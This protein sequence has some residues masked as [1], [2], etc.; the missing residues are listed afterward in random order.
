MKP[1]TQDDLLPYAEYDRQRDRIRQRIIDLKRHR[2]ISVGE[3]VTLVFENRETLQFQVQE[4]IRVERIVDPV[5]VP[6]ELDM[7]ND[8]LPGEGELSATLL[9][10]ITD[11]D[12]RKEQLDAFRG[13]DRGQTVALKA[14]PHVVYGEFEG[15]RSKD[16]KVSA[17]HFIRFRPSDEFREA[18]ARPETP[19]TIQVHHGA[20]R[21]E[22]AVQE[23][24]RREWLGDL[25][26]GGARNARA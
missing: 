15:G 10:E 19:V 2:R 24:V 20:Y 16:D 21:E 17:V 23:G 5:K 1:L 12:R 13:I 14:G 6:E 3:Y 7:Y 18:L 4:M 11:R 25:E 22:A 9:I 26:A 8:L